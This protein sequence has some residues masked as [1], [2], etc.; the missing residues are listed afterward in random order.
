MERAA[1]PSATADRRRALALGAVATLVY[2]AW[3]PDAVNLDGLGYLKRLPHNFAAGHLLYMPLLRAA[4]ALF[5]GD[6]LRAGR[7]LDA[8]AA[9]VAIALFF[10]AARVLVSR[11]AALLAAAG[12]AVS[13]AVWVQGAD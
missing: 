12:L 10:G 11:Q 7:A 3:P 4:T 9:A 8:L 6:G 1:T 13:S 5:G 2:L